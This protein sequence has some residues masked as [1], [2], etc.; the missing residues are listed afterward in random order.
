MQIAGLLSKSRR[1][2]ERRG[3]ADAAAY[4]RGLK[5]HLAS[6]ERRLVDL[7]SAKPEERAQLVEAIIA[8]NRMYALAAENAGEPQLARVLRAFAPILEN[9]AQ[10]GGDPSASTRAA[11][12]RTPNHAGPAGRWSDT[13]SSPPSTTL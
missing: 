9:V 2:R 4:E 10:D 8:Q 12:F 1:R 13:P 11:Q 5:W 7:E 3:A 6:T